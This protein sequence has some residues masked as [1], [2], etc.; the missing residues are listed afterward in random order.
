MVDWTKKP[1]G[2]TI[3]NFHSAFEVWIKPTSVSGTQYLLT[4]D[5]VKTNGTFFGYSIQ[6][7]KF[8][9]EFTKGINSPFVDYRL[10]SASNIEPNVWTHVAASF[11]DSTMYIF[12]NGKL[13]GTLQTAI[14]SLVPGTKHRD[15]TV[16]FPGLLPCRI[17]W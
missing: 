17:T 5:T 6:D 8:V 3:V 14:V 16:Y 13:E 11:Y 1:D 15:S 7:G 9:Y 4:R 12:I 2:T 10:S